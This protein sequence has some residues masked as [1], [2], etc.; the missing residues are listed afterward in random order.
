MDFEN[1]FFDLMDFKLT[2]HKLGEGSYGSVFIA[3][4]TKDN[5]KY[6]AKIIN[7]NNGFDGKDQMKFLRESMILHKFVHPSILKFYGINFQSFTKPMFLEPTIITEYLSN[8]SL[9]G[10]LDMERN[11]LINE[12]WDNTAKYITLIGIADA[13]RYL[14]KNKII[15]R[16]LKSENILMD[17]NYQPKVADFGLSRCFSEDFK[18]SQKMKMTGN[19][20]TPLYMAPE[21]FDNEVKYGPEIDVYAFGIIAYEIVTGKIPYQEIQPINQFNLGLKIIDGYRPQF[22]KDQKIPKIMIDLITNCWCENP[23]QRLTFEE[24]FQKLITDFTYFDNIDISRISKYINQLLIFNADKKDELEDKIEPY[25]KN[26]RQLKSISKNYTDTFK[27]LL[28]KIQNFHEI[29]INDIL[30]LK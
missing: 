1:L 17:E 3:E 14:H 22:D 7:T 21:L 11:H 16:D 26:A 6:A 12:K 10:I 2:N 4:N 13:M 18:N 24:I 5:K 8:G 28:P 25:S 15:H 29:Y 9:K 23:L 19:V 20:G 30:N 27:V